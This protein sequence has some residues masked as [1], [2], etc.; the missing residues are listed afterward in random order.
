MHFK[1][2]IF[3]RVIP[4]FMA[5]G[6][7]FTHGNGKGGRSIYG[8]KF[9]DDNFT[10]THSDRGILSMANTGPDTNTSQFMLSFRKCAH[11]DGKNVVIGKVI[12]GLDVLDKIEKNPVVAYEKPKL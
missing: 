6:G 8:K 1:G 11:L 10:K 3:H 9:V 7:D 5:Q 2:S 12:E 4:G